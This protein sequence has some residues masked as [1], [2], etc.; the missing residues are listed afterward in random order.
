MSATEM[1]SEI[2]AFTIA[3]VTI[4]SFAVIVCMIGV[5]LILK[6]GTQRTHQNFI[7]LHL[8]IIEMLTLLTALFYWM[9]ALL[10]TDKDDKMRV[11]SNLCLTSYRLPM[12]LLMAVI[13]LDRLFGTKYGL[14]YRRLLTRRK[15]QIMM[16]A[17]WLS[18]IADLSMLVGLQSS[19]I[20]RVHDFIAFPILDGALLIFVMY[21]YCN[22]FC[23]VRKR[24]QN[25]HRVS[26]S[27]KQEA[28]QSNRF[29]GVSSTI[30]ISFISFVVVPDIVVS[31]TEWCAK[32]SSSKTTRLIG[33][34]LINLYLVALPFT[35]VFMQRDVRRVFKMWFWR[36]FQSNS[37]VCPTGG[38]PKINLERPYRVT[39]L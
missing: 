25:L 2:T 35:F 11:I 24:A 9:S 37:K 28:R 39:G 8:S 1:I 4:L 29:L 33:Y 31:L 22:I 13:T 20:L 38:K 19:I 14:H 7:L 32:E 17:I 21:T 27:K 26:T 18:W 10:G 36:C 15:V 5:I 30:V 3:N 23:I 34:V 16:F 6:I 12:Y